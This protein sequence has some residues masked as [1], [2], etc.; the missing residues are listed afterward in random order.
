MSVVGRALMRVIKEVA[1]KSVVMGG[2]GG[3]GKRAERKGLA[4]NAG[5]ERGGGPWRA[6][7]G[8]WESTLGMMEIF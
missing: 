1:G 4:L 6:R 2:E 3:E 7:G 5:C 8:G